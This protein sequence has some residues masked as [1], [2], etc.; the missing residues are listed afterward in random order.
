MDAARE[1]IKA[2]LDTEIKAPVHARDPRDKAMFEME[3]IAD[4][5]EQ[6]AGEDLEA[7]VEA[8]RDASEEDLM[9]LDGIGEAKA[10]KL[11]EATK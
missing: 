10:K 4:A 5:V 9:A 2:T 6:G 3:A 8:I 7:A 11:K 1:R